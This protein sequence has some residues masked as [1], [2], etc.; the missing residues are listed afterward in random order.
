[1]KDYY[2]KLNR[3]EATPPV[4]LLL[5]RRGDFEENKQ[6]TIS[7]VSWLQRLPLL[8]KMQENILFF[9]TT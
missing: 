7:R 1:L 2:A 4:V 6:N 9:L 3:K 5:K 8:L